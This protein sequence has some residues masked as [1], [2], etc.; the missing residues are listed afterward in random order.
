[1]ASLLHCQWRIRRKNQILVAKKAQRDRKFI[2][3]PEFLRVYEHW[4]PARN[5]SAEAYTRICDV[6]GVYNAFLIHDR[7]LFALR[8]DGMV[9]ANVA[10][11]DFCDLPPWARKEYV[12]RAARVVVVAHCHGHRDLVDVALEIRNEW[13]R[14]HAHLRK[15]SGHDEGRH[16]N[17]VR[18][19]SA[20]LLSGVRV[21]GHLRLL[22]GR[23]VH[24]LNHR[25]DKQPQPDL[26]GDRGG[27]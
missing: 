12:A 26:D 27:A 22:R 11:L 24:E 23:V 2:L 19:C 16:P 15:F 3:A 8:E 13:K 9:W 1:M 17:H 7:R 4:I 20:R 21:R 18:C 14:T 25:P 5:A 6:R 10:M